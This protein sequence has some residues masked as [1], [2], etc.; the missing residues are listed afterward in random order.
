VKVLPG[1]Y[2]AF[3]DDPDGQV[4]R[5]YVRIAL[6]DPLDRLEPALRRLLPLLG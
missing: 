5:R 6:V 3:G 2:M 1:S 4:A